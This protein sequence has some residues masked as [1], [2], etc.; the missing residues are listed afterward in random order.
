MKWD[1][2]HFTI[3]FGLSPS[4]RIQVTTRIIIHNFQDPNLQLHPGK[5]TQ[6]LHITNVTVDPH[7]HRDL[8]IFYRGPRVIQ[9]AR[10]GRFGPLEVF[11]WYKKCVLS[12]FCVLFFF[13]GGEELKV[14]ETGNVGKN[15]KMMKDVSRCC[16]G[17]NHVVRCFVM[18]LNWLKQSLV[19][20]S[21]L[22]RIDIK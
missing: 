19:L 1:I 22:M 12:C 10:W 18:A 16:M 8:E 13:W 15:R 6:P 7:V 9:T 2:F 4:P 21:Q 17:L 5:D 14:V 20:Q 11:C 3:Y